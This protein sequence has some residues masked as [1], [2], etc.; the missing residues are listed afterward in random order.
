VVTEHPIIPMPP[1]LWPAVRE[2]YREGIATGDATFE[3]EI[4]DWDKWDS[5]HRKDC[6]LLAL[7]P[8]GEHEAELLIPLGKLSVLGWAALSPVSNRRVYAGVAEVSVYVAAAA[9]GRGVGKALLEALVE[10][11][12][13]NGIWMLQAGI[14]PENAAS[15]AL[16]KSCG[17]RKVGV[18]RCLGKLN[19]T[20]RDVVLLE[21]RSSKVGV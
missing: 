12:E 4:P 15:L 1:D 11:S 5:S 16:H 19:D 2:I 13:V 20:W 10:E 6:R 3:T 21:R 17:F 7:A 8:I 9:R 14:F 18:R